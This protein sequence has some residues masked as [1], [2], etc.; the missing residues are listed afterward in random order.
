MSSRRII[1]RGHKNDVTSLCTH[2]GTGSIISASEDGTVRVWDCREKMSSVRLLRVPEGDDVGFCKSSGDLVTVSSGSKLF[3][4]DLRGT[5]TVIVSDPA[6]TLDLKSGDDVGDYSFSLDGKLIAVPTDAGE[7][8]LVSSDSLSINSTVSPHS[9]IASVARFLP[10]GNQVAS[11][12]Y[13]CKVS[14]A[15]FTDV[16]SF[17]L[18]KSFPIVSL[19]PLDEDS[20][21]SPGQSIN[22]P[23]V[24]SMEVSPDQQQLAIGVGDGS[25]VVLDLHRGGS[26]VDSRRISWGGSQI[27]PVSVAALA[28]DEASRNVWSVGNDSVLQRMDA[29]RISVR[30]PLGFKPNAVVSLGG[31]RVA[32][33]GLSKDIE[34]L[35]FS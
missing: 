25:V 8:H 35:D 15:K 30:Y 10:C 28:W 17:R 9:N 22:P 4:Y 26:K 34:L 32:V 2:P 23:F 16:S 21:C 11:G 6:F 33:A 13:D 19:I 14:T 27:H 1:L 7:I 24:T 18:D 31:A 29:S 12:G 3:G 20:Q 5:N